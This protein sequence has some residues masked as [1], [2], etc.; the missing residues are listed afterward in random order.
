MSLQR[1]LATAEA[2]AQEAARAEQTAAGDAMEHAAALATA[3]QAELASAARFPDGFA[4]L[5]RLKPAGK[6]QDSR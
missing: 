1:A 5:F 4:K 3:R 2:A 6:V